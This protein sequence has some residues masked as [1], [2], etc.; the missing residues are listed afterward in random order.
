MTQSQSSVWAEN[1]TYTSIDWRFKS[2]RDRSSN[3]L[4]NQPKQQKRGFV[5]TT[6]TDEYEVYSGPVH[7]P[8][9]LRN[10]QYN[11][12]RSSCLNKQIDD[13]PFIL[14]KSFWQ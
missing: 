5:N 1:S 13:I 14:K 9:D 11:E 3:Q 7:L 10:Q 8:A 12:R 4:V 6:Q 2:Q